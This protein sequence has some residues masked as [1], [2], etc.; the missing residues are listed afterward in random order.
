MQSADVSGPTDNA[1]RRPIS[2]SLIGALPPIKGVS[3]YTAQLVGAL[4][5][6]PDVAVEFIGFRS[7]YPRW[8]YPGGSPVE[9]GA[10]TPSYPRV[11]MR[12]ILNWYDPVSWVRAGLTLRGDVV[13]AQWWSYVLAPV[14]MAVLAIARLR[15]KRVVITIHNVAPHE[16]GVIKRLLNR[17]VFGLGDTFIVHSERNKESLRQLLNCSD[18]RIVV[19]PHGLLE[20]PRQGLSQAEG[21]ARLGLATDR[22]RKVILCFGNIR[23]YKGIDVLIRAFADVA[24][25]CPEALL[26]IAGKPWL[27]WQPYQ[28][29]ISELGISDQVRLFLDFIPTDEVEAF[30]VASDI[31][32]L[33]YTTFDAQ[34]SVGALALPYGL[35]LVVTDVGG[36]ADLVRSTDAVVPANDPDSLAKTLTRLLRDEE[37]CRRLASHSLEVSR[38]LGWG[39]ICES[40]VRLYSRVA[41]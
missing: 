19:L 4:A 7:I 16:S 25:H 33:P 28:A 17:A 18:G 20:T 13:H 12:N 8:A 15:G 23:P 39:P 30:F 24:R 10:R 1:A 31:V 21:Q 27:S 35:P 14:Y 5:D 32:V 37:L 11:R 26:V 22:D 9:E 34:S 3:P 29:L 6:R 40:T 38:A 41:G 2:V 36:L